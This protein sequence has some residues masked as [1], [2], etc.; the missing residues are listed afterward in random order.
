MQVV[1]FPNVDAHW[2]HKLVCTNDIMC[3]NVDVHQCRCAANYA[4][5]AKPMLCRRTGGDAMSPQKANSIMLFREK[6]N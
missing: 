6:D 2:C 5:V 4:Q 1:V 3:T